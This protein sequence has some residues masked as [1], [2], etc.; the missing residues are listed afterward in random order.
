MVT[1]GMVCTPILINRLDQKQWFRARPWLS[2][3]I[4]AAVCGFLLT[5]TIPLG[6]AVFPQFSPMKVAQL[7]PEL[8]KKIRQKFVAR[9][10][11]VPE[12]VYYNKGL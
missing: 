11:P 3:L 8:Q 9:K 7:E 4:Q 12:L 6:C 2:P 5:F 1:P 10:L